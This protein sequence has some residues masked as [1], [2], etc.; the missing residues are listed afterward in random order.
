MSQTRCLAWTTAAWALAAALSAQA[1][2]KKDPWEPV[3]TLIGTWEGDAQGEPG[4]GR[5]ERDYRFVLNDRFIRIDNKSTYA[6]Q[7]KNPKGEVHE[8]AGFLSYDKTAG[9]LVLRQFHVEGFVSHYVLDGVSDDGRTI[10][11]TTVAIENIPSGFRARE[12]W[13]IVSA[14]EFVET[15]SMAEPGK[16]FATYS[17]TRFRRKR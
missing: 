16:D 12:T 2:V 14:D 3:R 5:S 15:F 11:F 9:K 10:V 6:P 8:D 17:E 7:P 13:R 4:T 1:P